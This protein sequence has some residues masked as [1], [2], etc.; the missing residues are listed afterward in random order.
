MK[1]TLPAI[2]AACMVNIPLRLADA[3]IDL[4]AQNKNAHTVN[5]TRASMSDIQAVH[6]V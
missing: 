1:A 3:G 2:I 6:L 4:W 5:V